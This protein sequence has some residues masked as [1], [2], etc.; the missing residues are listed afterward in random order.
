MRELPFVFT[1]E[2]EQMINESKKNKF[3][4]NFFFSKQKENMWEC[5]INIICEK[6]KN[7]MKKKI[8]NIL[9]NIFILYYIWF[10]ILIFINIKC[11]AL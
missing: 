9:I 11:Y 2:S 10:Y 5:E 4:F 7:T 8:K 6:L 3:V 1:N